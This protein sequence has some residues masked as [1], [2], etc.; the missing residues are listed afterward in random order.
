LPVRAFWIAL[1]L[2]TAGIGLVGIFVPLLPTTPFLLVA[3]YAFARSSP[4]LHRWLLEHERLGPL[5]RD[6]Q[7]HG[8]IRRPFKIVAVATMVL[9]L[10]ATAAMGF[11]MWIVAS[12]AVVLAA[13]ATFILTRP[14]PPQS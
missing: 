13:A 11:A 10:T 12:Q 4:R 3:S 14:E 2:L 5:L 1:G 9:S 8:S 6:W 7:Q